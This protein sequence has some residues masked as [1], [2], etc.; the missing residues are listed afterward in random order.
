MTTNILAFSFDRSLT[1]KENVFWSNFFDNFPSDCNKYIQAWVEK[2]SDLKVL[3]EDL[4]K[5]KFSQSYDCLSESI[6]Y[7]YFLK[8]IKYYEKIYP[9]GKKESHFLMCVYGLVCQEW[10]LEI[11]NNFVFITR[12]ASFEQKN[13]NKSTVPLTLAMITDLMAGR[14]N[15]IYP[16][17]MD[18]YPVTLTGIVK[19]PNKESGQDSYNVLEVDSYNVLEVE[20]LNVK[21]YQINSAF[22][23][24]FIHTEFEYS[25]ARNGDGDMLLSPFG[26]NQKKF[27][28]LLYYQ[29]IENVLEIKN[30]TVL[31]VKI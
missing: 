19:L 22:N 23:G 21:R 26:Q 14:I 30:R 3:I 29:K 2:Y 1:L 7:D 18:I 15:H 13:W 5:I 12:T 25:F 10:D 6:N 27:L 20:D 9:E 31:K 8:A 11:T 4:E 17:M 28:N 24:D 16:S